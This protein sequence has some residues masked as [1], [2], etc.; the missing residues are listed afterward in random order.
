[1][2]GSTA[3]GVGLASTRVVLGLLRREIVLFARQESIR[4]HKGQLFPP[5]A[6]CAA[7]ENMPLHLALFPKAT[8]LFALL[9]H[10]R[11]LLDLLF[12]SIARLYAKWEK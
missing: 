7:L 9:E 5:P 6:W 11:Q 12:A 1:M 4:L 2:R 8:V 10:I 3:P